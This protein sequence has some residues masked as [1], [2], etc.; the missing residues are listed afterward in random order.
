MASSANQF[1]DVSAT[2]L[3]TLFCRSKES[4]SSTPILLDKKAVEIAQQLI[5][6]LN[7]S[8]DPLLR[9]L[10][11]GKIDPRL[12]VHIALRAKKYDEYTQNFLARNP[13]GLVVNLGCGMDSRYIRIDDGKMI[14]FDLDLPDVI[15]YKKRFFSPD[16][17]YHLVSASVFDIPWREQVAGYARPVI[18]LAEGLFMYLPGDQVK[19]LVIDLCERFP[20][21]ELVCEMVDKSY[22]SGFMQWVS[23]TKMQKQ[24]KMGEQAVFQF[25]LKD[26]REME[27]WHSALQFLEHW[28]YFDS[29]HPRLGWMRIFRKSDYFR[30]IQ[31]TVRYRFRD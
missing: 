26:S 9:K 27:S 18:F 17:R 2:S 30:K 29:N 12:V 15:A 28:S 25:G 23:K 19:S 8:G 16:D 7:A 4:Q 31:Y 22:A 3:I 6:E 14:F 21:G 5:P 10:A 24:I 13:D 11:S 20:G 1:S